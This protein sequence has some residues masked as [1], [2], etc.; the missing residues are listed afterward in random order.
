MSGKQSAPPSRHSEKKDSKTLPKMK[1]SSKKSVSFRI[2]GDGPSLVERA[3]EHK[4]S[5]PP[6]EKRYFQAMLAR[7][8]QQRPKTTTSS[9][10]KA[11]RNQEESARWRRQRPRSGGDIFAQPLQ[12]PAAGNKPVFGRRRKAKVTSS[13]SCSVSSSPSSS[14]S[15]S[16]SCAPQMEVVGVR[17][18]MGARRTPSPSPLFTARS[19]TPLQCLLP[20]KSKVSRS[21]EILHRIQDELSH[22]RDHFSERVLSSRVRPL[23]RSL[24]EISNLVMELDNNLSVVDP[25]RR[26]EKRQEEEESRVSDR[27]PYGEVKAESLHCVGQIGRGCF[28]HVFRAKLFETAVAVKQFK[29]EDSGRRCLREAAQL[30]RI[31]H[32]NVANLVAVCLE[33][34]ALVLELVE[35]EALGEMLRRAGPPL[36]DGIL[37]VCRHVLLALNYLHHLYPESMIHLDVKSD[38]VLVSRG[39]KGGEIR[40]KLC[41]FGSAR[42]LRGGA[43]EIL[44]GGVTGT[45]AWMSPGKEQWSGGG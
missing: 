11:S 37:G 26:S 29:E 42:R 43:T 22:A 1:S 13:S 25:S 17:S 6:Y 23:S 9:F 4:S 39:G 18:T 32:P 19:P 5:P 14:S 44:L 3:G 21:R 45:P 2:G 36:L 8:S 33:R 7:L 30:S 15:S 12:Q 34:N 41:D 40:A 28:A 20:R 27:R 31:R 24:N 38:N 10:Y 16:P 35:G